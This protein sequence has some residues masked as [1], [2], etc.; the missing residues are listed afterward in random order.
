M[1]YA[2][3]GIGVAVM[4]VLVLA[5]YHAGAREVRAGPEEPVRVHRSDGFICFYTPGHL[6]CA[7]EYL[8]VPPWEAGP[9]N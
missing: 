4:A 9:L 1:K 7:P 5:G 2:I 3:G 6:E 8:A